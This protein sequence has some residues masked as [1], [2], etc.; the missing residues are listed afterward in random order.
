VFI[1]PRNHRMPQT[2]P[3]PRAGAHHS[4]G[5]THARAH[6]HA[7]LIFDE[8]P[9]RAAPKQTQNRRPERRCLLFHNRP[10]EFGVNVR[11]APSS[12][13]TPGALPADPNRLLPESDDRYYSVIACRPIACVSRAN[14]DAV[15]VLPGWTRQPSRHN[16]FNPVVHVTI[17]K[18]IGYE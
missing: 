15:A 9:K 7:G 6:R 3:V 18:E 17:L 14:C 5:S 12:S 13:A 10:R 8:Q 1:A 2:R 16:H 4:P 11:L